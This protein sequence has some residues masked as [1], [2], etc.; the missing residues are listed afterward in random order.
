MN[1][2]VSQ[3]LTRGQLL[4]QN[5]KSPTSPVSLVIQLLAESDESDANSQLQNEN[6][7]IT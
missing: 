6:K 4:A 5:H 3:R 1:F 7:F 2:M